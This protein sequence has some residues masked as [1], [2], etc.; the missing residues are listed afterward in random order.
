MIRRILARALAALLLTAA[1]V[2]VAGAPA[3]AATFA[4]AGAAVIAFTLPWPLLIGLLVSTVLPLLVGLVTRS[5]TN[6]RIKAILLAALA[7]LTGLL[8]ELGSAL[9]SGTTYDLGIGLLAALGA[10]LL[11]VGLHFGLYKP[12]G[13]AE[14]AQR[15]GVRSSS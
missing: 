6:G 4:T 2:M 5:N 8:S 7:A 3:S 15:V 14:A 13:V 1:V 11:A 9:S 10:F 12:T